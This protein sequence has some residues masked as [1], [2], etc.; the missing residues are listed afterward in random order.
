MAPMTRGRGG[1]AAAPP[2]PVIRVSRCRCFHRRFGGSFL[3]KFL[4][5]VKGLG[6]P[7]L[8]VGF[9]FF[10]GAV[11]SFL[12]RIE[13]PLQHFLAGRSIVVTLRS[14]SVIIQS[15]LPPVP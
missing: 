2:R 9:T 5:V 6:S 7:G 14:A 8:S 15:L 13:H 1:V 10:Y 11:D 4:Y 12:I 3:G